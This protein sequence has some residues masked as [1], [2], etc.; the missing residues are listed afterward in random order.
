[1][2]GSEFGVFYGEQWSDVAGFCTALVGSATVGEDLA[3]EAF[4]RL[5]AR[6]RLVSE[7]RPYVLVVTATQATG[8]TL[9][10]VGGVQVV[11]FDEQP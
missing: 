4:T 8:R 10:A 2:A 6:W 7:P 9:T 11:P 5:C 1:M 3:Q